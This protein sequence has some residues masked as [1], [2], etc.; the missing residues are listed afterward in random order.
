MNCLQYLKH[1]NRCSLLFNI[2]NYSVLNCNVRLRQDY[3]DGQHNLFQNK[4]FEY[5][6]CINRRNISME[7]FVEWQQQTYTSISNST[8]VHHMQDGLLYFHDTT[9]L[10]WWAT[11]VTSTILIRGLITLPLAI[12]QNYILAKVE[13]IGLELKD[14]V[15]E[16]KRE[17]A[18]A[19]K[20]YNLTD[21]Q[22]VIL[23]KRSLKKQWQKL[24]VRDNCHPFKASL[25]IWCQIPIWVCMSFAL[26]NLVYMQSGDPAALVTFMELSAGGFGWIPNLIEPDHSLILPVAF[27]LT[28]L[29]I[30]E[31]QKMSKLREPSKMYNVFTNVF[32][33]FSIVMIPVAASVPSC[34]CLY[35]MT[36]SGFGLLQNLCLLSPS[37]RRKLGIPEAPSEIEEPYNHIKDEI[38]NT[39][40]KIISKKTE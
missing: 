12:Y 1:H 8:L 36:S 3:I 21:K 22:A 16:L 31:I 28:N 17:T 32:R 5:Q 33:V 24:I 35:W 18:M 29:T 26:R 40:S 4:P 19:K 20:G 23:Y 7:G 30:I 34:M 25:V 2:R 10:T 6:R 15:N 38:K 37:I 39:V 14:M 27:G 11:V 13:N 9:G